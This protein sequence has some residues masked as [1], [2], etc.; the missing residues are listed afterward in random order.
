MWPYT[1]DEQIWLDPSKD[2]AKGRLQAIQFPAPAND[3]DVATAHVE[4]SRPIDPQ[5]FLGK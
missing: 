4:D 3:D 1:R 2:W 5:I